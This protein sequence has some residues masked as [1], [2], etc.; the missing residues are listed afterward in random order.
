[1]GEY[2][3]ISRTFAALAD[4]T[5]R[6]VLRQLMQGPARVTEL[7]HPHDISLNSVSKHLRMLESADLVRRDIRGRDHWI[8]FNGEPLREAQDWVTSMQEFW[9]SRLDALESLLTSEN[10]GR[11]NNAAK[12][13]RI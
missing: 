7:A 9:E 2:Q 4:P 10:S 3:G 8:R 11:N 12:K 6:A 5:R 13:H 1:M